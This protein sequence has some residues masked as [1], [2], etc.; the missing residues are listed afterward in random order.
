LSYSVDREKKLLAEFRRY[1]SRD[2]ERLSDAGVMAVGQHHG[3]VTRLLDWSQSLFVAAYF[4]V[5]DGGAHTKEDAA[6]YG[7]RGA[8]PL[9]AEDEHNVFGLP[10]GDIRLYW[11]PHISPRIVAQRG[12]F[13]LHSTPDRPFVPTEK[14]NIRIIKWIIPHSQIMDVKIRLDLAG[15]NRA[16]LF[17]DVDGVGAYLSW[18][19]KRDLLPTENSI[20][21]P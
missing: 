11:P 5:E 12:L 7:L 6:I 13:S 14:S 17:P 8:S 2:F 1:S 10:V 15:F 16:A 20:V 18:L 19:Y 9:G 3:L 4:A 21:N